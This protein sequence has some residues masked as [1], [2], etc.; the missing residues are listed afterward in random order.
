M[1]FPFKD[2]LFINLIEF[3]IWLFGKHADVL[4]IS[5]P[6]EGSDLKKELASVC[7]CDYDQEKVENLLKFLEEKLY[8]GK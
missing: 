1:N 7:G 4:I 8:L 3:I 6:I 2:K 5:E